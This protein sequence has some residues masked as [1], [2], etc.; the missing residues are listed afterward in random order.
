MSDGADVGQLT[1]DLIALGYGS[2][3]TQSNHYSSATAA[4]V[5]RWQSAVG[6]QATG[7]FRWARWSSSPARS[8]SRRSRRRPARPPGAATC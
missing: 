8:G 1:R 7:G 6:L 4:A 2:G 3:L 5:Q